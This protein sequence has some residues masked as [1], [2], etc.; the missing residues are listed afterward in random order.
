[1][2]K[3][4][5]AENATR[6]LNKYF[7]E[8]S[9]KDSEEGAESGVSVSGGAEG[10]QDGYFYSLCAPLGEPHSQSTSPLGK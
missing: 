7:S 4:K 9:W 2:K 3:I 5:A 6:Y 8:R 10:G 1:M